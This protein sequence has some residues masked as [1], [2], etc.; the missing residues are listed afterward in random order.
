MIVTHSVGIL[1]RVTTGVTT[2]QVSVSSKRRVSGYCACLSEFCK[3]DYHRPHSS[4]VRLNCS[5]LRKMARD[6]SPSVAR[7]REGRPNKVR[8]TAGEGVAS[9]KKDRPPCLYN[10]SVRS[11]NST[12]LQPVNATETRPSYQLLATDRNLTHSPSLT[13]GAS[14]ATQL[15]NLVIPVSSS[16][17]PT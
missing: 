7:T 2:V 15:V 5:A 4:K 14:E 10:C 16:M 9:N 12:S 3:S 6:E 17:S 1:Q 8:T 13:I 11:G